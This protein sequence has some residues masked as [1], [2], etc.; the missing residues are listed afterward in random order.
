MANQESKSTISKEIAIAYLRVST[1]EQEKEGFSLITQKKA[2]NDYIERYNDNI[3][4]N[5]LDKPLLDLP[6][7]FILKEVKPASIVYSKNRNDSLF[8]NLNSRPLLKTIL[9]M[10]QRKQFNHLIVFTR[11]R[12]TRNFEEFIALKYMLKRNGIRIHY[13]RSGESLDVEDTKISRFIDNI[14]ASVAELEANTIGVRVKNGCTQCIKN[15]NWAGGKAPYGYIL[16]SRK[17][18]GRKNKIANLKPSAYEKIRVLDIF[19]LYGKGFSYRKIAEILN[20]KYD[21]NIWTKSK[22]EKILKNET[23]TGKITWNRRG[24]RRHPNSKYE[25]IYSNSI[26]EIQFIDEDYWRGSADLRHK[27]SLLKDS[28]YYDTDYLL[29]GK[30]FC[31]VC[32]SKLNTKNYGKKL[33]VYRCPTKL[34]L[35]SKSELILYKKDIEPIVI[36]KINS[37]IN[38]GDPNLLWESYSLER[39]KIINEKTSLIKDLK[40]D[41]ENIQRLQNNLASILKALSLSD[42]EFETTLRDKLNTEDLNLTKVK[43]K[44]EKIIDE[45]EEF[46]KTNLFFNKEEYISSL[47]KFKIDINDL[48]QRDKRLFIDIL[49]DKITVTKINNNFDINII[50]NPPKNI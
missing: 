45:Y 17:V 37:Y 15:G 48:S 5:S 8:S 9:E 16:K 50:F 35:K 39:E 25:P 14:L 26:E 43:S 28:K 3:I 18:P 36:N 7:N 20:K 24:G 49:I 21:E 1:Q 30:L 19:S 10:A 2:A 13:S 34:E 27:K 38:N 6:E 32:G 47:S 4:K 33:L 29:K 31:G 42:K 40:L 44:R 11:D 46:I 12:L 23:Y 41:I 22:V